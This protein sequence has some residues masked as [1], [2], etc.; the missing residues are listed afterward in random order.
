MGVGAIAAWAI[1]AAVSLAGSIFG[2]RGQAEANR[3]N[4]RMAKQQM[5]F[6]ER[7]SSSSVQRSVQDYIAA[8]LNPALAY[9]RTASTPGGAT[10]TMGSTAPELSDVAS[11]A[12]QARQIAQS[13][14]IAQEQHAETLRNTRADTMVKQRQGVLVEEQQ[15]SQRLANRLATASLPH[16]LQNVEAEA[17]LKKL[18]IPGAR[19]T[20]SFEEMMGK[21]RPGLSSAKTVA[22]ILKLLNPR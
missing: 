4:A 18:L 20:A 13:M 17:A 16:T 8:G 19:N 6:Q 5:D 9:E 21:M 14:R 1:P 11:S 15:E 10:A 3:A 22:E 12:V 2:S 7:M